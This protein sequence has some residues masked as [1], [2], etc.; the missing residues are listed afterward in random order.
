MI[1]PELINRYQM[2]AEQR[3]IISHKKG[4]L[5]VVAGP[6]SGKTHSLVL[7]AMNLLLCDDAKPS[8]LVLCTYTEKAA[9]EM[10]DRIASTARDIGYKEDLAQLKINTIH[11][12]CKQFIMENLHHTPL[13]NDYET[14]DQFTQ[15]LLIVEHIDEIC[16]PQMRTF[17][18]HYWQ[19]QAIREIAKKLQFFFDKIAEELIFD[20]LKKALAERKF[21]HSDSDKFLY[22]LTHAYKTYQNVLARANRL[23]F[24]HLLKCAYNLLKHPEIGKKIIKGIRYVLVDEYQDTNYIQEQIVTLLASATD[25]RNICVVGDEDQ[26]LYRFRGATVRNI[27]EFADKFPACEEV[28]LVTNYRSHPSI[29][30]ICN[31]W[32]TSIDWSNPRGTPFRAEKTIRPDREMAYQDYPSVLSIGDIDVMV[33]AEQFADMVLFLKEQRRISDYSQVALLLYSVRSGISDAFIEALERKGIPVFCPRARTYF[34]QEEISLMMGCLARIVGYQ[35]TKQDDLVEHSG[36]PEYLR[37]CH[38]LLT[39]QCQLFPALENKIREIECEIAYAEEDRPI[40]GKQLADYFYH[41]VFTEPFAGLLSQSDRIHNLA[42]FS[43]FLQ[44]FRNY[45]HHVN[46]TQHNLLQVEFDLFHRFFCLLYE[47]GVNQYEDLQIPLQQGHV[48]IMTIHQAK[49][50]EFPVVAV[51]RLDKLPL[52]TTNEDRDLQPFYNRPPIEPVQRIAGFDLRRLYYVAFS[53]AKNLLILTANKKPHAQFTSLW[54]EIPAW[55]YNSTSSLQHMPASGLESHIPVKSRYSF[56]NHIRT[57]ETCPRQFQYFRKHKF[58]STR[59]LEAFSGLLV[60]QTL[61]GIHQIALGSSIDTLNEQK[62]QEIFKRTLHFLK[63][64]STFSMDTN[65]QEKALCQVLNYF[66]NNYWELRRI[67]ATELS[68]QVEQDDYILTGKI[69][70]VMR[71]SEGLEIIDFKTRARPKD[72]SE[73]L[74]FYKRQLYLYAYGMEKRMNQHPKRLLLYWTAEERKEDAITEIPYTNE[75]LEQVRIYF[76]KFVDKI[77]QNQFNILITPNLEICRSCDIR[78]LCIKEGVI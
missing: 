32:I 16:S 2:N 35:E 42:L 17:F 64:N 15:Q 70:L 27:L 67:E 30:N 7:L 75:D 77:K 57:Y 78:H 76:N 23:D 3:R 37:N 48:Q 24:A 74:I 18:H 65:E 69:D 10:Y 68:I 72:I 66:H 46:I 1:A 44:I 63:C 61:E 43:H 20:N 62:V 8:Q 33:E 73:H 34:D 51:G 14:L 59:S 41:F 4:P 45:Y 47:D 31:R 49:G 29:I 71:G 55:Q 21:Y 22:Y 56:T 19:T 6:G 60:H 25:D 50:L 38:R 11:G 54:Q 9:H 39:A 5:L 58:I 13:G 40:A 26:A 53:R 52:G 28:H 36:L 12:I